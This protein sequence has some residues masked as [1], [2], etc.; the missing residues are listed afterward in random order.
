MTQT[1]QPL[2]ICP[3]VHLSICPSTAHGIGRCGLVT[4]VGAARTTTLLYLMLS[5]ERRALR[6]QPRRPHRPPP[7]VGGPAENSALY[8]SFHTAFA[9]AGDINY[10][11]G[12]NERATELMQ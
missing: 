5:R 1:Q 7:D 12:A 9:F 11:F 10:T 4:G 6:V 8:A 3:S 2:C